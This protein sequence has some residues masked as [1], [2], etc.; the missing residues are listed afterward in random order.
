MGR[1]KDLYELKRVS[2][3]SWGS[4]SLAPG[5]PLNFELQGTLGPQVVN[6]AN[7]VFTDKSVAK[8]INQ[9]YDRLF[10]TKK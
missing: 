10:K 6:S 8:K 4:T 9:I 3:T 1:T 5:I 2:F 7:M